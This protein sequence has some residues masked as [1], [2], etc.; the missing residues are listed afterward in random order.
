MLSCACAR[1]QNIAA[2]ADHLTGRSLFGSVRAFPIH[3]K[4][5]ANRSASNWLSARRTGRPPGCSG[6]TQNGERN[7]SSGN[8]AVPCI[9][10]CFRR[11]RVGNTR[12]ERL[13]L[14][15]H[16]WVRSWSH[17][18]TAGYSYSRLTGG[19][20][21]STPLQVVAVWLVQPMRMSNGNDLNLDS[22]RS[23][24]CGLGRNI[25]LSGTKDGTGG[26]KQRNSGQ[27]QKKRR[28]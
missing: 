22:G 25:F 18:G 21:G 28:L 26:S 1:R 23:A 9:L 7:R 6:A 5:F 19:V 15:R 3:S 4:P 10:L 2:V 17:A 13:G 14:L 24:T 27:N 16:L 20:R 11:N 8:G 12:S